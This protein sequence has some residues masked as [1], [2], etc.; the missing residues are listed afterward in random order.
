MQREKS[1]QPLRQSDFYSLHKTRAKCLLCDT[2]I[3]DSEKEDDVLD[4]YREQMNFTTAEPET[5]FHSERV[6]TPYLLYN[7]FSLPKKNEVDVVGLGVG[8]FF[9][10]LG[11]TLVI[12]CITR[13]SGCY[14]SGRTPS[15][16]IKITYFEDDAITGIAVPVD[17]KSEST[18]D[19]KSRPTL[20]TLEIPREHKMY[21]L[22]PNV[23][24]EPSM[25]TDCFIHQEK[26]TE[27]DTIVGLKRMGI[28]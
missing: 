20:D 11:V 16:E 18:S 5:E 22:P 25:E 23:L 19:D 2:F 21:S 13:A 12:Y 4:F 15:A 7:S 1:I 6:T 28:L 10:V 14:G 27:S 8:V 9:C 3:K 17:M 26:P 24:P